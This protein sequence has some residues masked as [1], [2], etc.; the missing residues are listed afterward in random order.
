MIKVECAKDGGK[1]LKRFFALVPHF[2][3]EDDWIYSKRS[4]ILENVFYSTLR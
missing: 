4:L 3:H 2:A 1:K